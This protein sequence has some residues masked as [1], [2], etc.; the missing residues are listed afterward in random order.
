[1]YRVRFRPP[2]G[3]NATTEQDAYIFVLA[4]QSYERDFGA[5]RHTP[6]P[7]P[8]RAYMPIVVKNLP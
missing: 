3:Y 1:L 6:T 2:A 8:L 4:G 5:A 7:T